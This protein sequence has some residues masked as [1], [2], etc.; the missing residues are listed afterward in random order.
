[1][2]LKM[3]DLLDTEHLHLPLR[4]NINFINHVSYRIN[5]SEFIQC[6]LDDKMLENKSNSVSID[7]LHQIR[8]IQMMKMKNLKYSANHAELLTQIHNNNK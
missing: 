5:S 1:M 6:N 4:R 7:L 3:Q 2:I 8:Q